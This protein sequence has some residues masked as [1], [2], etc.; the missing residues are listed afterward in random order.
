LRQRL[1]E[2]HVEPLACTHGDALARAAAL[3]GSLVVLFIGSSIGNYEDRDAAL[4]LRAVRDALGTRGALVLG[5]DLRK[6]AEVLLPAYDDPQGVTAAFNKN[7]LAHINRAY[8]ADF[9]LAR[10]RHVALWNDAA[11]RMEMY[12][13]SV[14]AQRVRI[15]ALDLDLRFADGERIHTESS[16]KY[17][18][19]RVDGILG[20][21]GL[22]RTH[23]FTDERRWFG[24]HVA[25]AVTS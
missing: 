16:H 25:R 10:F 1:P 15:R 5:T 7:A 8:Q 14:G 11:S 19:A 12:L 24:V 17:D 23:T 20:A 18:D 6:P 22:A 21:A 4:L 13:Q 2:V 3:G 9:D